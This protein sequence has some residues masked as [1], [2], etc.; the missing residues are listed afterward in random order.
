[1]TATA[2]LDGFG[3]VPGMPGRERF[4]FRVAGEVSPFEQRVVP[5]AAPAG[6][7]V[8]SP[9]VAGCDGAA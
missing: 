3:Q 7:R 2:G 8:D 1:M 4:G 5:V 9:D 6:A